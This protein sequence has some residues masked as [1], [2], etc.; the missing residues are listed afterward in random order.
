MAEPARRSAGELI[1]EERGSVDLGATLRMMLILR[2]VIVTTLLGVAL[3]VQ[4]FY[5]LTSD[6]FYFIIGLTYLL[7]LFYAVLAS[8][9]RNSGTFIFVQLV[10]DVILI[11]VLVLVTGGIESTFIIL[12]FLPVVTAAV[13]LGRVSGILLAIVGSGMLATLVI[14]ANAGVLD[15]DIIYPFKNPGLSS[16]FYTT[17]LYVVLL[18]AVAAIGG[19][20]AGMLQTTAASLRERTRDLRRLQVLNESIVRSITSGLITTDMA[21]AISYI[22]PAGLRLIGGAL[23]DIQGRDIYDFLS[24]DPSAPEAIISEEQWSREMLLV[25][26]DG[27]SI[28]VNVSR[29]YLLG[30]VDDQRGKLYVITD[31]REIREL[32]AR[33]VLKE[34]LAAAGEMSAAIAHEI[35]N[36]LAAIS[37]SAQMIRKSPDLDDDQ[38]YLMD[39]I[40]RESERL[41][42]TL[43]DFLT[44]ARQ[45]VFSPTEID[46]EGVT[47]ETIAL[48]GN[49][50]QVA[51]AHRI[52]L[53]LEPGA[54]LRGAV[55]PNM[56]KQ[57][58][59]NLALNGVRAMP[60]G[61]ILQVDLRRDGEAAILK[62]TDG[63]VGVSPQQ[64]SR[65]FQP[66]ATASQGGT[67][68][69]LAIV[70]RIVQEHGGQILVRSKVG[71]GTSMIVTLPLKRSAREHFSVRVETAEP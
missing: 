13:V 43:N 2:V 19:Y 42:A 32:R 36:P 37:G 38:R 10:V 20:L 26:A 58:L 70:Y 1:P 55:D 28:E 66:F 56:Y 23:P 9:L 47:R 61:G 24:F 52:E 30:P 17:A 68:L 8:P 14:V 5:A 4:V 48:L 54:D 60:D 31:L 59:Y 21:G 7:T 71:T 39:I 69:G 40:T 29:S 25:R 6:S 50:P 33:L 3:Y 63:G 27:T 18:I 22:N 11:S 62:V 41:S 44:F 35:R 49:S 67:G 64:L 16:L 34:R 45:P 65:I 46:L 53:A 51:R 12:Y 57:L 15:L